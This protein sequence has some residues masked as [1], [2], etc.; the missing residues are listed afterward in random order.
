MASQNRWSALGRMHYWSSYGKKIKKIDLNSVLSQVN[1]TIYHN[2][3]L[4]TFKGMGWGVLDRRGMMALSEEGRRFVGRVCK[5]KHP[6]LLLDAVT[7]EGRH[8]LS[9]KN[10]QEIMLYWNAYGSASYGFLWL[11]WDVSLSVTSKTSVKIGY[12]GTCVDIEQLQE[13]GRSDTRHGEKTELSMPKRIKVIVRSNQ[14][15]TGWTALT[16]HLE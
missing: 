9:G 11:F 12:T 3:A 8:P 7:W 2:K 15:K 6:V 13:W 1:C 4:I 16:R 14:T 5:W 10:S